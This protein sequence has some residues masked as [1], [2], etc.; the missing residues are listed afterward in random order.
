M[1]MQFSEP[2]SIG[3]KNIFGAKVLVVF[4]VLKKNLKQ[5]LQSLED[6]DVPQEIKNDVV[7]VSV[8]HPNDLTKVT[9][10]PTLLDVSKALMEYWR[11]SL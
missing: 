10:F 11:F 6:E 2:T 5:L 1:N 3:L 9:V 8:Q 7:I 4:I